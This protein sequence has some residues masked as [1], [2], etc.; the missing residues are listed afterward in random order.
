MAEK[1]IPNFILGEGPLKGLNKQTINQVQNYLARIGQPVNFKLGAGGPINSETVKRVSRALVANAPKVGANAGKQAI[2]KGTVAGL[3]TDPALRLG[4][5]L[6]NTLPISKA[7]KQFLDNIGDIGATLDAQD[8]MSRSINPFVR[9]KLSIPGIN[10][11]TLMDY[12]DKQHK[13]IVAQETGVPVSQPQPTPTP[14]NGDVPVLPIEAYGYNPIPAGQVPVGN[15]AT[16][17]DGVQQVSIQQN[18]TITPTGKLAETIGINYQD[19]FVNQIPGLA[20]P[21]KIQWIM[22][23][24][25][26]TPDEYRQTLRNDRVNEA[27]QQVANQVSGINLKPYSELEARQNLIKYLGEGYNTEQSLLNSQR[28]IAEAYAMGE[29]TGLPSSY[30]MDPEKTMQYILNPMIK[31]R[32]DRLGYKTLLGNDVQIQQM[33]NEMDKYKADLGYASD[34]A[35]IQKDLQVAK[36]SGDV[37]AV[38]SLMSNLIF[39][40]GVT[41]TDFINMASTVMSP[42]K[43]KELLALKRYVGQNPGSTSRE[44]DLNKANIQAWMYNVMK[45]N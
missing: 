21:Q 43:A 16:G 25:G 45:G 23:E 35:G 33:K 27:V 42:D 39:S 31:G 4:N 12:L 3:A 8:K 26:L 14:S 36:M 13:E 11:K 6:Y 38:S 29:A 24:Y 10:N 22:D 40:R 37:K 15:T 28:Q 5:Y 1:Y 34:M 41:D 18:G 30:F 7:G 17:S 2:S 44:I 9:D 32:E 20:N 19:P